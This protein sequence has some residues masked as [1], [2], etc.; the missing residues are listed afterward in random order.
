MNKNLYSNIKISLIYGLSILRKHINKGITDLSVENIKNKY[1]E[2]E[3]E[4]KKTVNSKKTN[5]SLQT[6]IKL[7]DKIT[8]TNKYQ[9]NFLNKD[10]FN[11]NLSKLNS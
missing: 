3:L 10:Q 11:L 2:I 6:I 1:T 4:N 8:N 7:S 9:L 5:K